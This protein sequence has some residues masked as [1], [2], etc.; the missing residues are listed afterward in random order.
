[1]RTPTRDTSPTPT[2]TSSAAPGAPAR[3]R[4]PALPWYVVAV[5][6][7]WGALLLGWAAVGVV[8]AVAWLTATWLPVSSVLDT[9]GDG[10]LAVH[11]VGVTLGG[12]PVRLPPLGLTVLVGVALAVVA[13][14]AAASRPP[15]ELQGVAAWRRVGALIGVVATSYAAAVLVVATLVGSPAQAADAFLPAL[16][17]GAVGS[18]TGA[19]AGRP[20]LLPGRP[21]WVRALPAAIGVGCA[22][23]ALASA[24]TLAFALALRWDAVAALH[25]SLAPDGPGAW[26][27]AALAL[28]YGPTILLWSGSWVLG[29]GFTVGAGTVVAPGTS[30]L[31]LLPALPVLG[32]VPTAA[33]PWDWAV[34]SLGLA[35]GG[36]AGWW[37]WRGASVE[38]EPIPLW[39]AAWQGGLAGGGAALA[40]VAASWFARGA[41]GSQ[42][43]ADLGPRFPALLAHAPLVLGLGAA[44]AAVGTAAYAARRR[45]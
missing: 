37:W 36:A 32:A 5:L 12:V 33:T 20:G 10:W 34:L 2:V 40:W 17:L 44:A 21:T 6:G 11:G 42:R 18:L 14:H 41:L 30:A 31:G 22:V 35:A 15:D 27:L 9:V 38:G 43:L 25:A 23:M 45:R 28:A 24:L 26:L 29:A 4:G 13:H 16:A 39:S 1:M 3:A 8:V 19:T 7:S